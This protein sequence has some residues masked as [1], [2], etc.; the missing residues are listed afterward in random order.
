VRALDGVLEVGFEGQ[1]LL[2][3]LVPMPRVRALDPEALAREA[4]AIVEAI[5]AGDVEPLRRRTAPRIPASWPDTVKR[6]IWPRVEAQHGRLTSARSLGARPLRG[7]VEVLLALEHERGSSRTRIVFGSEGLE[8]LDWEGPEFPL[9]QRLVPV[10]DDEF[11]AFQDGASRTVRF[12]RKK[13]EV[14][15]VELDGLELARE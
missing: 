12:D 4:V 15:V 2:E 6:S 11:V 13:G 3:R 1:A 8:I 5:A 10:G 7:Q 9:A 14:R